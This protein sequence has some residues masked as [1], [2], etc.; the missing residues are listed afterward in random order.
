[1]KAAAFLGNLVLGLLVPATLAS[2]ALVYGVE[3]RGTGYEGIYR[4]ADDGTV[5]ATQGSSYAELDILRVHS[6]GAADVLGTLHGSMEQPQSV[7]IAA[8]NQSGS[9]AGYIRTSPIYPPMP[10]EGQWMPFSWSTTGGLKQLGF[11]FNGAPIIY[12]GS[13]HAISDTGL[14]AGYTSFGYP[15]VFGPYK[16]TFWSSGGSLLQIAGDESEAVAV[17]DSGLV[18]GTDPAIGAFLWDSVSGLRA[19]GGG[20][21][22]PKA[23][24]NS[25]LVVGSIP[26]EGSSGNEGFL[27][28][29]IAGLRRISFPSGLAPTSYGWA[30]N[31]QSLVVTT[32]GLGAS[33]YHAVRWTQTGG[34]Q[35]L[36]ELVST[37]GLVLRGAIDVN[38]RGQILVDGRDSSNYSHMLVLHLLGDLNLDSRVDALDISGFVQAL[39]GGQSERSWEADAN[40]DGNVNALD[41]AGFVAV[42]TGGSAALVVPEPSC[43][44]IVGACL[45]LAL[46]RRSR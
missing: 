12:Q 40:G 5:I 2:A 38:E 36:N 17:N 26:R 41:I 42:L 13:A 23:L 16:A 30:I 33:T 25:G 11:F 6:A 22:V 18:I 19:M 34:V 9:V 32:A 31:E 4:L 14:C 43:L 21:G 27:W 20:Q 44:A 46:S 29:S 10:G 35:D 28:D 37:P 24:N 15:S 7:N 45:G 39:V 1:M 3:D 8:A